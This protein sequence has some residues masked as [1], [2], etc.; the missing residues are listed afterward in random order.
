MR[1]PVIKRLDR[2]LKI[3]FEWMDIIE[4]AIDK[5]WGKINKY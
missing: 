4:L 1:L 5:L 3:N 2:F